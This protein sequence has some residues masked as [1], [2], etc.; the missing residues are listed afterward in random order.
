MR[1]KR[2][3]YQSWISGKA[4]AFVWIGA[5]IFPLILNIQPD[6][7]MFWICAAAGVILVWSV[8]DGFRAKLARVPS[9]F[10]AKAVVPLLLFA[11]STAWVGW[12][13]LTA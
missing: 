13:L 2:D 6:Q 8:I 4:I 3:L 7:K 9:D 11:L 10:V 12:G 1:T 5:L